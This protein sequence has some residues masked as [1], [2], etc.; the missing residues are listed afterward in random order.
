MTLSFV[1]TLRNAYKRWSGRAR[2]SEPNQDAAITYLMKTHEDIYKE[3]Q[4]QIN[5]QWTAVLIIGGWARK[6]APM[7]NPGRQLSFEFG[8][9][10]ESCH[11]PESVQVGESEFHL[12]EGQRQEWLN[13]LEAID[14]FRA[15]LHRLF[16]KVLDPIFLEQPGIDGTAAIEIAIKR[17]L[18]REWRDDDDDTHTAAASHG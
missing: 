1:S 12:L 4:D 16:E 8:G 18:L 3:N 14:K 17:G 9:D 6:L 2:K 5:R 13:C 10:I 7:P 15:S 11:V